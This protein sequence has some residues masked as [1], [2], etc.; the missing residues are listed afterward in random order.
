MSTQNQIAKQKA[1]I[2]ENLKKIPVKT[3]AYTKVGVTRS[4]FYR[5]QSE[6][7][8]FEQLCLLAEKEGI[9]NM[10]D[11]TEAQLLQMTKD[12][13]WGS[14]RFWLVHNHPRFMS[15]ERIEMQHKKEERKAL[16]EQQKALLKET[17]KL[18]K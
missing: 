11:M 5:W 6:D 8:E 9:E 14:V 7:K 1:L 16:T 4:T 10:N 13:H 17:L 3:I 12:R 2:V 18:F 15:K